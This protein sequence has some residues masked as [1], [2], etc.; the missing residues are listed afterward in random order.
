MSVIKATEAELNAMLDDGVS[1]A[2]LGTDGVFTV[3]VVVEPHACADCL[4]PDETLSAIAADAL[5]RHG[6]QVTS[7]V[8]QH[9]ASDTAGDGAEARA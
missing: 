3:K 4:V 5:R 2:V 7:V 6:A 1:V 9:A 8:V